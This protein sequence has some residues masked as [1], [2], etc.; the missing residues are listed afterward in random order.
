MSIPAQHIGIESP[1]VQRKY[2]THVY[3]QQE[4]DVVNYRSMEHQKEKCKMKGNNI[5]IVL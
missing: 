5:F 2:R 4:H 1:S 3:K